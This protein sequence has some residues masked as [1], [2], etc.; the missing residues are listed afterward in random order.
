MES[1]I[2]LICG[3]DDINVLMLNDAPVILQ[4]KV[5]STGKLLYERDARAASDFQEIVCKQFADFMPDYL[6]FC[7]D[8]DR[9]LHE[10]YLNG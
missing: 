9:F 10:A 4:F 8:Y 3:S 1:E 7:R 2:S 5:I 6:A